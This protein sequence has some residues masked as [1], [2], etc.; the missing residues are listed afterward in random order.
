MLGC[1]SDMLRSYKPLRWCEKSGKTVHRQEKALS[2]HEETAS[3]KICRGSRPDAPGNPAWGSLPYRLLL[4]LW[5]E[6]GDR[7]KVTHQPKRCRYAEKAPTRGSIERGSPRTRDAREG[8]NERPEL[9]TAE[10]TKLVGRA[11]PRTRV[12]NRADTV[13][14][15]CAVRGSSEAPRPQW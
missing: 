3:Q 4:G 14:R 2:W 6:D 11:K 12:D 13:S 10:H 5:R 15:A 9:S 8:R 7:N 1:W